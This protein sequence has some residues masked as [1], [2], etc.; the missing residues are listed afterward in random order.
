M[1]EANTTLDPEQR[2]ELIWRAQQIFYEESPEIVTDYPEKLEAVNTARWDGWTRMYGGEGAAFYTSYI[3]D[4]YLNLRPK[5]AVEDASGGGASGM[6][7]GRGRG[8]RRGRARGGGRPGAAAPE[9][10]GRGVTG[11]AAPRP[12]V[13]AGAA[14]RRQYTST[15][16]LP[17][18]LAA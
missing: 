18:R 2:K 6:V 10:D 13:S 1:D 12:G 8:G 15:R 9:G 11:Q 7:I 14:S 4:S 3:R 16:S 17:A 5:A